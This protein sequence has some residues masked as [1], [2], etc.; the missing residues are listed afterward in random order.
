MYSSLS[1]TIKWPKEMCGREAAHGE[2]DGTSILA[3]SVVLHVLAQTRDNWVKTQET[4]IQHSSVSCAVPLA[5]EECPPYRK[6]VH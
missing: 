1:E 5:L 3:L 4:D 6:E 2:P